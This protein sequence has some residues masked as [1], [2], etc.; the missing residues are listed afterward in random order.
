MRPTMYGSWECVKRMRKL[1]LATALLINTNGTGV[2]T[3]YA[4]VTCTNQ[5][6]RALSAAGAGT[7]NS[8]SLAADVSGDLPYSS[9]AQGSALSVLGVAG[10]AGADN[11]SIVAANDHEVFR[12]SGTS[13]GFGAIALNQAAA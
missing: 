13:V 8:V 7:C 5:F 3:A 10:N 2:L 12:R 1:L 4:G 6:L 9:L 11:A